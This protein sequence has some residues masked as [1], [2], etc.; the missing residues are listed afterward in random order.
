[1]KLKKFEGNPILSPNPNNAWENLVVCNPGAWYEDGKF[2]MLYRAAG[3]DEEHKIHIGLAES[4]DGFH[5]ERPLDTPVL[6]P[7]V[8]GPDSGCVE[9]P[10]VV[11]F[12]DAYYM[13]YAYR[14]FA[15][16][17]YWKYSYDAVVA[18]EMDDFHP[19]VLKENTAN[20][21]LAVSKDLKNWRRVGRITAPELDDRDVILFPE[22]VNGKYVML[23]RPKE[24][25]GDE[26]GCETA[27]MWIRY[28]ED[29]MVW[30][31]PSKLLLKGEEWWEQKVGGNTPPIRT[32]EG[33]LMLY[34]GVDED[35]C[36]RVGAC[37]LDLEDPSKILYRT[38]DFI[39]EPE[40]A[41]E[42]EG[43]YKWGVVFPTGNVLVDD[44]LYIYYGGSDQYCGVATCNIHELV[45][46]VKENTKQESLQD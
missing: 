13:T 4:T 23:H 25:I 36:Y 32:E 29:M 39:M 16:G 10:R 43:L 37:L 5:F 17:Q 45:A 24:W 40:E 3:D 28:S 20:T 27:S 12:G 44:T 42:K 15:P 11:K 8:D 26:F 18:P 30:N 19:S 31:E 38:K 33:W 2:Y 35:K 7:S 6:S 22:Q 14:A 46:F 21:A 9:D 1:M 41:W 34:H